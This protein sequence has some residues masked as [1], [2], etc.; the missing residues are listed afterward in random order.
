[1]PSALK[2]LF[3]LSVRIIITFAFL[4]FIIFILWGI[5]YLIFV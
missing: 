4:G 5:L 1:M 2:F 3:H